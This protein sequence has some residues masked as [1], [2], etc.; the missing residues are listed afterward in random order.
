MRLAGSKRLM[1]FT[2]SANPGLA[3]EVAEL[4][5]VEL[6]KVER[7]VF[8]NG[9]IYVRF[10]ESVR[11]ADCVVIQSHTEPINFHIM[12]Q[13]IMLDALLE[14]LAVLDGY[15]WGPWTMAFLAGVAIYVTLRSGIFQIA[16]LGYIGYFLSRIMGTQR[17]AGLTGII[18]GL[19]SSTAVTRVVLHTSTLRRVPAAG[20]RSGSTS[21]SGRSLECRVRSVSAG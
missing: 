6:G 1:L 14:T 10:E 21:R 18:G 12:E 17:S 20:T 9:E 4:L 5:G 8:A 13:L 3:D 2:G 11:G 19:V 7:S 16:G 15:L